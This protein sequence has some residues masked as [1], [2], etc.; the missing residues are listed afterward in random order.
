[1]PFDFY[2]LVF[3][4][5]KIVNTESLFNLSSGLSDIFFI[6]TAVDN[7]I[8]RVGSFAV[9]IRFQ[10]KWLVPILKFKQLTRYI[11]IATKQLFLH[12]LVLKVGIFVQKFEEL[13]SLFKVDACLLQSINLFLANVL[14]KVLE[15]W[16]FLYIS[17]TFGNTFEF[18]GLYVDISGK[19]LLYFF[20]F[21]L[22]S[23][24]WRTARA[25][26]IPFT[27]IISGYF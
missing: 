4:L 15:V 20:R 11:V 16:R 27:T 24:F 8:Y 7:Y 14:P 23:C 19:I 5:L 17:V 3:R 1:M 25:F 22:L 12:F 26:S 2:F 9:E 10:D 6:A 18:L 21:S 13:K